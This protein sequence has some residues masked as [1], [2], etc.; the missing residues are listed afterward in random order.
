MTSPHFL[1]DSHQPI[2][3]RC[4]ALGQKLQVAGRPVAAV[5][6]SGEQNSRS[7]AVWHLGT[8]RLACIVSGRLVHAW[9]RKEAAAAEIDEALAEQIWKAGE[10]AVD[11]PTEIARQD[12]LTMFGEQQL[13]LV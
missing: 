11:T 2:W 4:A 8:K 1:A 13:T 7:F 3:S 5:P 9:L 10:K 6:L 12:Q